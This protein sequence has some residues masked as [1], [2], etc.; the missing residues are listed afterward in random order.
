MKNGEVSHY[1]FVTLFLRSISQNHKSL[2][3]NPPATGDESNLDFGAG[4]IPHF[5]DAQVI[6]YSKEDKTFV[7]SFISMRTWG[8]AE[9]SQR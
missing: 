2:F 6:F 4:N 9:F 5:T 1:I 3:Q 8:D 7:D